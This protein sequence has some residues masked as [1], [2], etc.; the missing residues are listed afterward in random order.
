[1]LDLSKEDGVVDCDKEVPGRVQ[2][3][4]VTYTHSKPFRNYCLYCIVCTTD[5][6]VLL[7]AHEGFGTLSYHLIPL[8]RVV[9]AVSAFKY[10][11]F[12]LDQLG[13]AVS[14]K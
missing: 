8:F 4:H 12:R 11:R 1:M 2:T 3:V 6:G 9:F 14:L 7:A 13:C 5:L 10:P